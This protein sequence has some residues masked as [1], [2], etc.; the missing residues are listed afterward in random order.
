VR[1]GVTPP[2]EEVV[3]HVRSGGLLGHPTETLYGL[4]CSLHEDA[5]EALTRIKQRPPDKAFLMLVA[6][7]KEL[8]ALRWTDAARALAQA[9]WPGPLTLILEDV[10]RV[11]PPAVRNPL[12]GVAVRKEAHP[13]CRRVLEAYEAPLIS[14]SANLSGQPPASTAAAVARVGA[15]GGDPDRIWVLDVGPIPNGTG[16]T[17]VDCTGDRPSIVRVGAIQEDALAAA[18]ARR[19]VARP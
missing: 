11:L 15:T 12:G 16:S 19:P 13:V 6:N 14:T 18:L 3:A 1:E 4:G 10:E 7:D 17:L 9:F 8:P 5:L 2:W